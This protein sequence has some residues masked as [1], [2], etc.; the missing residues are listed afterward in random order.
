MWLGHTFSQRNKATKRAGGE[1]Q[2][3]GGGGGTK[4]EK[5]VVGNIAM[6]RRLFIL[7]NNVG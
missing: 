3:Q 6:I 4:F 5:G 2:R 7:W 1:G